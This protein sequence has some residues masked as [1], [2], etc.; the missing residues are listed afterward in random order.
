MYD[1]VLGI[2]FAIEPTVSRLEASPFRSIREIVLEE[3][4]CQ[5]MVNGWP[6]TRSVESVTDVMTFEADAYATKAERMTAL[7]KESIVSCVLQRATREGLLNRM[8]LVEV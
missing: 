4:G 7:A 1:P 8:G 2:L 5:V 3:S 6:G